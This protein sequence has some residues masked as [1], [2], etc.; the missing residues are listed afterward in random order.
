MTCGRC[1]KCSPDRD[2]ETFGLATMVD[3]PKADPAWCE[4]PYNVKAFNINVWVERDQGREGF[5]RRMQYTVRDEFG[6]RAPT[7][8]ER[9]WLSTLET[10]Q[11]TRCGRNCGWC[12]RERH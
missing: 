12:E 1:E 7:E 9:R 4:S 2:L 10:A 8:D 6:W 11:C 5:Q 3:A